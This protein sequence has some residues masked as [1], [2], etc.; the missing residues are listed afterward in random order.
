MLGAR[1]ERLI[2][3]DG[4]DAQVLPGCAWALIRNRHVVEAGAVGFA[5]PRIGR[6][7]RATTPMR[8][9]SISK[10]STTLTAMRLVDESRLSLDEDVSARLG[11][12]LRNPA[13]PDAPIT[14]K[15]LLSHTSSMRDGEIYYAGLGE[16]IADFFTPGAPHWENG[17]HW[18]AAR[19]PGGYFT[20][21]NLAFG[22]IATIVERT[23][24]HRFDLVAHERVFGPLGLGCGFNWSECERETIAGGS[25][26]YRRRD[27]GWAAEVDDPLPVDRG[28]VYLN[29][30]NLP[31]S[32]YQLGDN[33]LLFSP[34]GGLRASVRDL[35][36]IGCLLLR[37][38]APLMSESTSQLM[39]TPVW[40]YDGTNGETENGFWRG[41][42][43][44][45]QLIE[46]G[47]GSPIPN[48]SRTLIGHS[49]D[50]YGL[51]GGVWVDDE[52]GDGFAFLF[53]GGPEEADRAHGLRSAFSRPEE[54]AMAL[55]YDAAFGA[56]ATG[57]RRP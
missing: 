43:Q 1:L 7:L 6:R 54:T 19:A 46:P 53:N 11:F 26:I 57:S 12:T 40:R 29:P 16:K 45:L 56:T 41:Y 18:D 37:H 28:A 2:A 47:E 17:A 30:N 13:F 34:Q 48:Q 33:G 51:R 23:E 10:I 21:C 52:T 5:D 24:V 8:V 42:A 55:L 49:G 14:L 27:N 44:G 25:P 32:S 39:R 4:D 35:A 15:Q 38:G 36:E 50:A 3:G 9:A 31:L 22:V 20:Y